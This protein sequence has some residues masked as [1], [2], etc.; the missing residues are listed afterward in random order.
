MITVTQQ[1]EEMLPTRFSLP[2][3]P[4]SNSHSRGCLV[5]IY[6]IEGVGKLISLDGSELIVGRDSAVSMQL[7]DDSV[8]RRHAKIESLPDG[9]FV[10]DLGSTNGT[11]VNDRRV[12]VVQLRAGDR[13]RFGNQIF[14]YLS[15]S[16]L[17]AQYHESVY[18]IMTTDG[19][20]QAH[21]RRFFVEALDREIMRARRRGTS[22]SVMM[23]DIDHFKLINDT[24][25]HLAGDS[26]LTEFV[27]RV[28][29]ILH[30]DELLARVGGEEFGLM[31]PD[32]SAPEAAQLAE[33]IRLSLA[34]T[35]VMTET[36]GIPV[37]VS[38]GVAEYSI[39]VTD[40]V[41]NLIQEADRH[42]Y[43]A[44]NAGRNQVSFSRS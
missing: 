34:G 11:W 41:S 27:R 30:G 19:L 2:A 13:V 44:K 7:N 29:G 36:S 12:T 18:R 40:T 33:T 24:W 42:L 25:G 15:A 37:T 43:V 28:S 14:D 22:L 39:S 35:P 23:M 8:S 17:E 6:P 4:D 21:N 38:I 16:S 9:D 3:L 5:R 1:F 10:T 31:V 32:A 20:T 26:V